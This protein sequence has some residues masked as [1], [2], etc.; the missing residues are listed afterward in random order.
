M[1]IEQI[2][3]TT[4]RADGM[5]DAL[6]DL[7]VAQSK[8]ETGNYSSRFFTVGNNAFGYS[9]QAGDKWQLDK[10]GPLADNGIPIA[11]YAS[12]KDSVHELTAWIKRRQGEGKFPADLSTITTADQYATLLKNAGYYG[13]S[14]SSYMAGVAA[15]FSDIGA[16]IKKSPGTLVAICIGGA[17][18]AYGGYLI[19]N[20]KKI[21]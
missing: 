9:Y 5:P 21:A 11:Q 6:A 17:A 15:F 12:V 20:R 4:A 13:A 18:I 16:T 10:G 19:I 1:T 7:M 2:I 8:L 3:Y 14:L